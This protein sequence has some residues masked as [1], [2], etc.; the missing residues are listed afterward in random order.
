MKTKQFWSIA[1]IKHKEIGVFS[2]WSKQF[3]L[4]LFAEKIFK[5]YGQNEISDTKKWF[6]ILILSIRKPLYC[7][8]EF[9]E[10][11]HDLILKSNVQ[12]SK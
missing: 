4:M 10:K 7:Q 9:I 8:R 3:C 5:A 6:K 11:I 2:Y 12:V 1:S